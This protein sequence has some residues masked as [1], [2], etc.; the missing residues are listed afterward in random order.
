MLVN[1]ELELELEPLGEP[2]ELAELLAEMAIGLARPVPEAVDEVAAV[3]GSADDAGLLFYSF[4][5]PARGP[6]SWW[7]YYIKYGP[8]KLSA[9]SIYKNQRQW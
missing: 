6:E 7:Q 2:E 8:G 1:L 4:S 9:H 3:S 5:F